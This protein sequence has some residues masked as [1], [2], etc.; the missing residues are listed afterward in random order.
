[1]YVTEQV[2]ALQASKNMHD[3]ECGTVW[4][5]GSLYKSCTMAC[6]HINTL[7]HKCTNKYNFMNVF[8]R[9]VGWTDTDTSTLTRTYRWSRL[10]SRTSRTRQTNNSLKDM[11]QQA[12]QTALKHPLL[13]VSFLFLDKV[14]H[15]KMCIFVLTCILSTANAVIKWHLHLFKTQ[16]ISDFVEMSGQVFTWLSSL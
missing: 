3:C 6:M 16:N 10:P 12:Y 9:T 15:A 4:I 13:F 14:V 2:F 7:T 8:T 1:M 11:D 5:I